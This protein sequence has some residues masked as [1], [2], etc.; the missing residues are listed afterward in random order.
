M[1]ADP[2]GAVWS[3]WEDAPGRGPRAPYLDL[4]LE[5]IARH[6]NELE[7]R[8]LGRDDA[9][10]W[11]PDIDLDRWHG[12]PAPNYRSDYAR[13]RLL[14][15]HG[16][17]WIDVDTIALGPLRHL[18]DELDDTGMVCWGQELGRFFGGLCAAAAG[19]EFVSAW[20]AEQDRVLTK[21]A[22][23]STLGY[24]ALAQD[25]TWHLARR[26]PWKSIPIASVSPVPWYQWRRF[27]SRFE[28]PRHVLAATPTTV[29]L[30]NAV[31]APRLAGRTRQDIL[32]GSTL[33]D[34]LLRLG[35][36][37]STPDE[38]EDGY[39]KFHALAD[40]RFSTP[41]RRVESGLRTLAAAA[42]RPGRAGV[43]ADR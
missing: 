35:L 26:H 41:G 17:I 16:G 6:A 36:G 23:W 37:T 43:R 4:C 28:S 21:C 25:I 13:S 42:A 40:L 20:A 24:A 33:L 34:R 15:R 9:A 2:S 32:A 30:W 10:R 19:A 12:L 39:T 29:V 22:D 31:M 38:E 18:L 3:Y 11:L 8:V 7:L 14:E 5:T 27:F 1:V